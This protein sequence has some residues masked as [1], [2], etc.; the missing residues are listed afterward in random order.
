VPRFS[1][2]LV[3]L[4]NELP[5]LERFEAA[6]AAGFDAVEYLF[7]YE[8]EPDELQRRLRANGLQQDL[9]NLPAGDFDAGERGLANDPSRRQEFRDGV[10]RALRYA[11][12]LDCRK[13]NCLAGVELASVPW[14]G[15]FACLVDN[16]RYAAERLGAD[17][18]TLLVELLNTKETPG[19]FVGSVAVVQRILDEVG[20]PHLRFQ[21]DVY[22]LQRSSGDLVRTVEALGPRV[23][24]VQIADSPDRHQPGSGEIAYPY[25]LEAIDRTGYDGYVGLEYRPTGDT[26]DS[27]G[28]IDEYGYRLG[29]RDGVGS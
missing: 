9:F 5:F 15:Q 29:V 10:E 17:G 27:F 7:P 1:A 19:F 25:V 2:N 21:C 28:W 18:R 6:A 23:G 12:A 20:S 26:D 8:H 4:W 24:H 16:L 3:F 14:E 11:D 13:L 22:H